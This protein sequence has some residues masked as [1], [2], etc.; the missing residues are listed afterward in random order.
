M[1]D[2]YINDSTFQLAL[3][4]QTHFDNISAKYGLVQLPPENMVD[5]LGWFVLRKKQFRRAEELFTLN[6]KNYPE[7]ARARESLRQ[8]YAAMAKQ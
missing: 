4:L 5:G 7:S 3:F 8:L 2:D 1:K 6:V